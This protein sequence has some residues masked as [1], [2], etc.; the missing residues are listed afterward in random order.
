MWMRKLNRCLVPALLLGLAGQTALAQNFEVASVKVANSG[1]GVRGAC[2]GIDSVYSL[3]ATESAPPL[4][5]CVITDARLSHLIGIAFGVSMQSLKTGPDWIQRGDLRFNVQAKAEDP[6]KTTEKQ[7][8]TMLQNLLIERFQLKFHH[9][10]KEEQGFSLTVAKGGPKFEPSTSDDG[11]IS[12][13][14]PSGEVGKPGPGPVIMHARKC[15]IANLVEILSAIGGS[16]P[17]VDHT[18]LTGEYDFTLSWDNENGPVLSTSLHQQLGLALKA[19]K[20]P[21]DTLIVD[22]AEKPTDN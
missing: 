13:T 15:S 20:V 9:D 14:G 5:R 4:G 3:K 6:S 8:L 22:S 18:G 16:G 1:N 21:F 11:R 19:E 12:F 10:V 7:L 2:R 17:G